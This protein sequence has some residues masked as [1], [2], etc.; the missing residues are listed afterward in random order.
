MGDLGGGMP[1]GNMGVQAT[2]AA[3]GSDASESTTIE[4]SA[5]TSSFLVKTL[6][7]LGAIASCLLTWL[8]LGSL[9]NLFSIT[10]GGQANTHMAMV[11]AAWSTIPIGMRGLMQII[12]ALA[13][14]ASIQSVGL[15]GFAPDTGTSAAILLEKLLEQIDIYFIWQVA[16]L[17]I[18]GSVMTKLNHKKP[19]LIALCSIVTILVIKCL[20]GLGLEKLSSLEINSS[21]LN[22][23]IR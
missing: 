6:S 5:N 12:Y 22:R 2:A 19:I 16:L 8:I 4:E 21:M 15:S 18:G 10:F 7:A 17:M 13:T 11:F 20:L 14:A 9:I 3:T 23:L 1:G